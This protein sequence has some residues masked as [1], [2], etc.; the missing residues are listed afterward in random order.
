MKTTLE[1][2]DDLLI[3]AK[4]VA[5]QRRTTLKALIEHALRRELSPASA[6]ANP[7][8]GQFEVG[9]LGFLVLK[10]NPGETIRLD[11][12]E[13]IQHELEEAELQRTLPPK[14]R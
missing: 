4:T 8:P 11:Q 7:D 3:E 10:R 14:K 5:L 6:E 1:L 2:P 9:P 12:I 13:S